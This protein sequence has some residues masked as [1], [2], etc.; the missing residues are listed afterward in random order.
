MPDKN[1][2]QNLKK[3]DSKSYITHKKTLNVLLALVLTIGLLPLSIFAPGEAEAASANAPDVTVHRSYLDPADDPALISGGIVLD[4]DFFSTTPIYDHNRVVQESG[5]SGA[6]SWTAWRLKATIP[7]NTTGST[8]AKLLSSNLAFRW[9]DVGVDAAN[10]RIDLEITWLPSSQWWSDWANSN[11]KVGD[12]NDLW[13]ITAIPQKKNI[14]LERGGTNGRAKG[15]VSLEL[16]IKFYKH[17]TSTPAQGTFLMD[18]HD[19]DQ[20]GWNGK[21]G[22]RWDESIELISGYLPDVWVQS[23]TYLNILTSSNGSKNTDFRATHVDSE[24][25]RS[26]VI[27]SLTASSRINWHAG[28]GETGFLY[29]FNASNLH[30]TT[31][32]HGHFASAGK[33][34]TDIT[35]GWRGSRSVAAVPDTGY[36]LSS[37]SRLGNQDGGTLSGAGTNRTFSN[38]TKDQELKATFAPIGYKIRFNANNGSGS[39]SDMS[40]TY[41]TAKNLTSNAFSRTGYT[42]SGW[43]TKADGTGTSYSNAQSVKNLT[44]SD[45]GVVTLYAQWKANNYS[46]SFSANTGRGTMENQLMTYD[47]ADNLHENLFTKPGYHFVQWNLN[48]DGSGANYAEQQ[49]VSNLTAA[50]GGSVTMYAQWE[51][52]DPV[53]ITYLA[54]DP[55]HTSLSKEGEEVRPA[56]GSASGSEAAPARGYHFV[57]WQDE[58]GNVVGTDAAFTP[59]RNADQIYEEAAYT[60]FV[61]P[62]QYIVHYDANGGN[63]MMDDHS[64]TYDKADRLH[65]N[66]FTRDGYMFLGWNTAADGTGSGY[67]DQREVMNLVYEHGQE[68]TLY[69]QWESN[70]YAIAFDANGGN[71]EMDDQQMAYN[72]LSP[73]KQNLFVRD[74]YVFTDWNTQPDG[75]G[76]SYADEQEVLN[77]VSARGE[78][79][80]LYAQWKVNTYSV[81]FDA[82]TGEGHMDDQQMV[83][84]KTDALHKNT[85]TKPGYVFAGWNTHADGRGTSY[86]DRQEVSNLVSVQEGSLR[87]YAQ[88]QPASYAIAFDANGGNGTMENQAMTY[89]KTDTL[90]ENAFIRSGY[91]FMGWNT[92]ADGTGAAY[93][94]RQPVLNLSEL[95]GSVITLYAVWQA[96]PYTIAFDANGGDGSM[97]NQLMVYDKPDTL[98]ENAFS[99]PGYAFLGWSDTP[100]G[101][102][103]YTDMQEVSNLTEKLGGL[104]SLYAVWQ[105]HPA[106]HIAYRSDDP[107]HAVLSRDEETPAPA[108]GSVSGCSLVLSEGYRVV[109]WKD[110]TDAVVSSSTIL[111]PIKGSDG[112]WHDAV[113][114]AYTEPIS[115]TITFDANTGKGHMDDQQMVYDKAANLHE[116]AFVKE[117]YAFRG[118][119]TKPDGKGVWYMDK[120]EVSNLTTENGSKIVLY[121]QWEAIPYTVSFVDGQGNVL[122]EQKVPFGAGAK[123]PDKPER[124]GY[125]FAGWDTDYSRVTQD[126]VVTALWEPL[127]ESDAAEPSNTSEKEA[128]HAKKG[129]LFAKTGDVSGLAFA[130]I[131]SSLLG[132]AG[133]GVY[134][135]RKEKKR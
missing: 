121:A 117:G 34:V 38:V 46:I 128:E 35:I 116:N 39:M 102:V 131:A 88:W 115:Y 132:F 61:E 112:L 95:D 36:K 4:D 12:Q 20:P 122:S 85:F 11:I 67:T 84:D 79:V 93:Q 41:D 40:M 77:L 63:G 135:R 108:T 55:A 89:D 98:H 100:G 66:A 64:M 120:K 75:N 14:R 126:L 109:C 118:W 26:R 25:L 125:A 86:T 1:V 103:A 42:F 127:P 3:N 27:F 124:R 99:R 110:Q 47:K 49:Q 73:L 111:L 119:N 56:T 29:P 23:N 81:C 53:R 62:N 68:I 45:G 101:D 72:R 18:M 133:Y 50:D 97:E 32:G 28:G 19:L 91:T 74:G 21:Y 13:L 37:I 123:A 43:N 52:N 24:E 130:L 71:G 80:T 48:A 82:N 94:D 44:S 106:V 5:G 2:A 30:L 9:N 78:K 58:G 59:A 51:E 8:G 33:T 57:S 10:D 114:T 134:Q 107:A 76:T 87:L 22:N 104:V 60:A 31:S 70:P 129:S 113:Y 7:A 6:D 17:G 54:N 92:A 105:E 16:Q 69:A 96:H 90:H 65:K 83:Y 15:T